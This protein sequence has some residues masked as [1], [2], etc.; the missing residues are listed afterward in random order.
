MTRGAAKL[1]ALS[2]IGAFLIALVVAG[3]QTHLPGAMD[4]GSEA[5]K[6][7]F[8]GFGVAATLLY[9]GACWLVLRGPPA[10]RAVW[11]VLGVAFAMRLA[12]MAAPPFLSTDLYRYIWDGRVQLTGIDVYRYIPDDPALLSLRDKA[13]YP[14][15]N[16]HEYAHTIYPPMAQLVFRAIVAVWQSVTMERLTMLGFDLLAIGVML[17]L[18][19]I[20]GFDPA[21]VLIYAW[22]PL[23]AWEF[24]GNGHVDALAIGLIALAM[25]AR[26]RGRGAWTGAI[27]G[28]AVLV[29]F[30]PIV[31]APALWRPRDSRRLFDWMMPTAMAAVMVLLYALYGGISAGALGF[32]PGYAAQ[33][34]LDSGSGIYWLDLLDRFVALPVGAGAVWLGMAGIVLLALGVWMVFVRTPPRAGDPVAVARDIVLLM[35]VL[36]AAITPHY[37]WYFVWLALPACLFPLPSVI[38]LSAAAMIQYHDPFDD[39]VLQFSVIYLPFLVLAVI[40]LWRHRI[41]R[42]VPIE[43][44]VRSI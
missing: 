11:L 39:R 34:G 18:L 13:I 5:R 10:R 44:A 42:P 7:A 23:S 22:N 15:V 3:V 2:L 31:L 43:V 9:F 36:T 1:L 41:R 40:D 30:L 14:N 33:E 37:A 19:T 8:V 20:A 35:T 29:K 6:A 4:E 12:V 25:L 27:L 32:L 28:A 24:A 17:R 38:Y 21:R 26:V 16:R